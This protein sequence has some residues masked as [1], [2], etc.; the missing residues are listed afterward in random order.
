MLP[1]QES[2]QLSVL[3][4]RK[5]GNTGCERV[6]WHWDRRWCEEPWP[7]CRQLSTHSVPQCQSDHGWMWSWHSI[8]RRKQ[9]RIVPSGPG[10]LHVIH[11]SSTSAQVTRGQCPVRHDCLV[12][13][14]MVIST[15]GVEHTAVIFYNQ[16]QCAACIS[17]DQLIPLSCCW[18]RHWSWLYMIWIV[19]R[20]LEKNN[21]RGS[22]GMPCSP[23]P[24][25]LAIWQTI[26][27]NNQNWRKL[28]IFHFEIESITCQ[29]NME[30]YFLSKPP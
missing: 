20:Q 25:L 18:R 14:R 15:D 1:W 26:I 4:R 29:V 27:E 23:L 12:F 2:N 9:P 6:V 10:V 19:P 3:W 24:R 16:C 8:E 21:F 7:Q 28:Q 30:K 22:L 13:W 5:R 17:L 11:Q